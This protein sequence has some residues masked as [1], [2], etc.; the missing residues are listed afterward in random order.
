MVETAG[1]VPLK[2]ITQE[3]IREGRERRADKPHAA[4]NFLKAMRGFFA[5]AKEEG[6]IDVDPTK[7]VIPAP[8]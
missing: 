1:D 2:D 4:N 6:F 3:A 7:G 5:W 8:L